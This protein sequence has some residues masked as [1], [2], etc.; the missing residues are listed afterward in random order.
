MESLYRT[1]PYSWATM[2]K[3]VGDVEQRLQLYLWTALALLT[4]YLAYSWLYNLYLHPL[5]RFPGPKLAAASS[6]YEFW[7]D[8][9]KDGQYLWQIEKMHEKYGTCE[10]C[11]IT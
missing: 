5:H 1:V 3:S 7:Y 8:V 4:S 6:L 11:A 10:D 9:I 2:F